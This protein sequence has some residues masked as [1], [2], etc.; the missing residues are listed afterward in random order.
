MPKSRACGCHGQVID[1]SDREL[2]FNTT[3]QACRSFLQACCVVDDEIRAQQACASPLGSYFM[4]VLGL[5]PSWGPMTPSLSICSMNRAA[6]LNPI[7][8]W[9]WI[10]EIEA[11]PWSSTMF[12][13]SP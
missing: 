7:L 3:Q 6:L 2:F 13:A 9:R 8:I 1:R 10:M 4:T 12:T 5:L 11:L